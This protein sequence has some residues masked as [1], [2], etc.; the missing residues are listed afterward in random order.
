[1]RQMIKYLSNVTDQLRSLVEQV[2]ERRK[3]TFPFLFVVD[4]FLEVHNKCQVD[5]THIDSGI[6]YLTFDPKHF[7]QEEYD[8]IRNWL[9][10]TI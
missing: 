6:V 3:S 5:R 10:A 8:G 9:I 4:L 7:S 2:D 1:M